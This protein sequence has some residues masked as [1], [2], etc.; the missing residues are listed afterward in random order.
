MVITKKYLTDPISI[1]LIKKHLRIYDDYEDE[2]L[3]LYANSAVSYI[4]D[5]VCSPVRETEVT[6]TTDTVKVNESINLRYFD[7]LVS[8]KSNDTDIYTN[9]YAIE[10]D[11]IT[12][13]KEYSN[14]AIVYK[15][16][17]IDIGYLQ[18]CINLIVGDWYENR[19]GSTLDAKSVSNLTASCLSRLLCM[20]SQPVK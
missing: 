8:I 2:L 11:Y 12:F 5:W 16:R 18:Q 1:S 6:I 9:G 4:E 7:S 3:E 19:E 10:D 13:Y 15:Q 14:V 20:H 17:K